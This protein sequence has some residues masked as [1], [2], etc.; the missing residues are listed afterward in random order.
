MTILRP[1]DR[2]DGPSL[3]R[4]TARL[5]A[6]PVP[7]H[8][9][10]TE[11][12]LADHG[13]LRRAFEE[14]AEDALLLVADDPVGGIVGYIFVTTRADYFTG[15]PHGH[16]EI[17]TVASGQE[18]K[19]VGRALMDAAEAWSATRGYSQVTLNVFAT[20]DR[21]RA[22][23]ARLGYEPELVRYRKAI[24]PGEPRTDH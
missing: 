3:L 19:G 16:V 17:L 13:I 4:L 2:T 14:P 20:N 6:F 22:V 12:E 1:A 10:A 11:I 24:P 21:A 7:G 15:K 5:A 9:Q 23:Y 18:G 8:R